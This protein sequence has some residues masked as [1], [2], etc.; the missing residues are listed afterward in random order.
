M[1]AVLRW[2]LALAVALAASVDVV[3]DRQPTNSR[4]D[5]HGRTRQQEERGTSD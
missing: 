1:R 5:G 4:G 3:E 2:L